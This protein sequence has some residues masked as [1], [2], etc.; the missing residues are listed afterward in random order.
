MYTD[1]LFEGARSWDLSTVP[2]VLLRPDYQT[3]EPPSLAIL[4][5][6]CPILDRS[7]STEFFR[8]AE[9]LSFESLWSEMPLKEYA[10]K[11]K[12]KM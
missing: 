10:V 5:K 2:D 6:T 11:G 12:I 9:S 7:L 8:N 1:E 4:N 3:T